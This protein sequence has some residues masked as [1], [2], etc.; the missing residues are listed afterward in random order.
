MNDK[1]KG[2]G[3]AHL[4]T[5]REK[6][7][8]VRRQGAAKAKARLCLGSC[9]RLAADSWAR[10]NL[11]EVGDASVIIVDHR[12]G[13]MLFA[14]HA[15]ARGRDGEILAWASPPNDIDAEPPRWGRR[16]EVRP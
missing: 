12:E 9:P 15:M 2:H 11:E 14:V 13:P 5:G 4:A 1:A 8:R 10:E 16:R 6:A 3:L 7:W